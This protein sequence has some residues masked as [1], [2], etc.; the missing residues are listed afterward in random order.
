MAIRAMATRAMAIPGT[1]TA[2]PGTEMEM[3]M[4]VMVMVM[5][6]ETG[7]VMA[8]TVSLDSSSLVASELAVLNPEYGFLP[9]SSTTHPINQKNAPIHKP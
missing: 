1:G 5:A 7:M 4:V 3:E 8:R 6:M 2:I 9:G